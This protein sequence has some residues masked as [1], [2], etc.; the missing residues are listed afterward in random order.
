MQG[1]ALFGWLRKQAA[2]RMDIAQV[3]EALI[4]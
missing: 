3:S 1:A 4:L 2:S